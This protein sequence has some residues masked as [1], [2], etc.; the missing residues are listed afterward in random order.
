MWRPAVRELPGELPESWRKRASGRE[1]AQ[2]S[3]LDRAGWRAGGRA[4]GRELVRE[5]LEET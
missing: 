3:L 5:L 1:L 4:A 2:E